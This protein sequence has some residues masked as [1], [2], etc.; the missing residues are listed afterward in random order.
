MGMRRL[1]LYLMLLIPFDGGQFHYL[2]L[3]ELGL[4]PSLVSPTERCP[5]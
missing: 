5:P 4:N 1:V 3:V 2:L